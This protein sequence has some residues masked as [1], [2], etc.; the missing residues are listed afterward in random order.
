MLTTNLKYIELGIWE[1]NTSQ[2]CIRKRDTF[3]YVTS[4]NRTTDET[5]YNTFIYLKSYCCVRRKHEA[6]NMWVNG[7]H[8]NACSYQFMY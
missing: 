6:E 8:T 5:K 3:I 1:G 4:A 2:I 7:E